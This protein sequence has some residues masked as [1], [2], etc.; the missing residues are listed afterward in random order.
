MPPGYNVLR[1]VNRKTEKSSK[2]TISCYAY[3]TASNHYQWRVIVNKISMQGGTASIVKTLVAHRGQI[4][5]VRVEENAKVQKP[6]TG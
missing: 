6:V 2:Q 5:L 4:S 1:F 3:L